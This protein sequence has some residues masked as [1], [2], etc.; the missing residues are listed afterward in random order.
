MKTTTV[1]QENN[2]KVKK[3]VVEDDNSCKHLL[4]PIKK[5]DIVE[6][7]EDQSKVEDGYIRIIHNNEK[8]IFA[9]YRFKRLLK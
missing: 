3:Y 6:A 2:K 1:K 5:G 7:D 9:R 4:N 8:A